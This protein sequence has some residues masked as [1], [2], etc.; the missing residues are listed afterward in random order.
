MINPFRFHF[1]LHE[2]TILVFPCSW[3]HTLKVLRWFFNE[4]RKVHPNIKER[5]HLSYNIFF[6]FHLPFQ[7]LTFLV[8]YCNH[9]PSKMLITASIVCNTTKCINCLF[10]SQI[11]FILCKPKWED[12]TETIEYTLVWK[13]VNQ[14]GHCN[15]QLIFIFILFLFF[16]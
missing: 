9:D 8:L 11:L 10:N 14:T 3:T 15:C 4:E 2:H 7:H 13:L 1:L 12:C 5:L 6:W 16:L